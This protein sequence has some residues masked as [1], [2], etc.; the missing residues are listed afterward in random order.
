MQE[1]TELNEGIERQ[2][3]DNVSRPWS[4]SHKWQIKGGFEG[5]SGKA[6]VAFGIAM[7]YP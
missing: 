5:V 6:P 7:C 4:N 3:E 2:G 1:W